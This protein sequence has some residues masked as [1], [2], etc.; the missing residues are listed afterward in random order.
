MVARPYL[1]GDL[2]AEEVFC[3]SPVGCECCVA[4]M[5]LMQQVLHVGWLG[6]RTLLQ[7]RGLVT[8]SLNKGQCH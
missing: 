7:Q 6:S 2:G 8:A 1:L 3:R 4:L 5:E